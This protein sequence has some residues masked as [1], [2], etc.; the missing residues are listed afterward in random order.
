MTDDRARENARKR[1]AERQARMEG[2]KRSTHRNSAL[3]DAPRALVRRFGYR[4]VLVVLAACVLVILAFSALRSCAGCVA[5]TDQPTDAAVDRPQAADE[6]GGSIDQNT[7]VALLG[8]DVAAR[9]I[10]AAAENDDVAWIAAHPDAY[11]TD[12]V[13]V[14]RKL[15]KLAAVEPEA[16]PFV[17]S[18]PSSYPQETAEAS[19]S[20]E[21]SSVP[22]LYQWDQRWGYT[23]YSSTTFALTGCCPT[24]LAMIYQG[25]TGRDD[26]S[27]Y[28]LALKARHDGFESAY[29]GTDATFLVAEAAGLGLACASVAVDSASVRSALEQGELLICNV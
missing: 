24:S 6:D 21:G 17:R 19:P 4:R 12:G 15:L 20:I 9:L 10:E 2:K 14:Q 1:L 13:A 11:A 3:L 22:S 25:L 18:F 7:L 29:D 16:V 23:V 28:D 8:D 5:S 27:P 26:V